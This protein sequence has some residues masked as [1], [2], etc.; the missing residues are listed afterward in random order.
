M[1]VGSPFEVYARPANAFVANFIGSA[2][3][4]DG[5]LTGNCGDYKVKVGFGE[6]ALPQSASGDRWSHLSL[7]SVQFMCRP[8][9]I[10][11]TGSSE[12]HARVRVEEQLFL[13]DRIRVT[14]RMSS[15]DRIQFE[16]NY[17]ARIDQGDVVP[18]QINLEN[19]HVIARTVIPEGH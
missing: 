15:G 14:A 19:V 5:Q 18:I 7:G 17:T 10:S 11:I 12:E 8:Q 6:F 13:G 3:L 9:D 1:Q 4:Y 2:N 16:T